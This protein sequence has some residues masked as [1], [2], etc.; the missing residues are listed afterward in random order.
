M[1]GRAWDIL[2]AVLRQVEACPEVD[3]ASAAGDARRF[4]PLVSAL[5]IVCRAANPARA[6]D[7]LSAMPDM[8]P[9]IERDGRRLAVYAF[10]ERVEIRVAAP[11]EYGT[12]LFLATGSTA[13][14]AAVQR[15]RP[16]AAL[17]SREEDVY[18]RAGLPFI[19]PEMRNAEGEL[20]AAA[21][22]ALPALVTRSDIRGDLHMH[23]NYSDG[24][25]TLAAMVAAA[26][27]LGYEYI[28]ITDHSEQAAALRTV[29]REQL[30]R[31]ADDIARIREQYPRMAVLHGIE[32]EIL[33]DGSLDF[34][35]AVLERLDVVL[36][37]LHDAAGHDAARLTERCI[38]AIR[39]PL[40]TAITHPANQLVGRRPGYDLRFEEIYAAAAETGTA[41]EIDGAPGHLDLDGP[42]ARA[43]VAAGVTVTIDSDCHRVLALDA[44]MRLGIGTARRG[45]VEPRN[46]LNTRPLAEVQAFVAAKRGSGR[47]PQP[48]C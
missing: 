47:A 25:D 40:V 10:G 34:E 23:T 38:Q 44:Q 26:D 13:H 29:T 9:P 46:V 45:W 24:R 27:A 42:H 39:H 33:P 48:A 8:G 1:L 12:V 15:R 32:V 30:A 19:P 6:I 31:Q 28:A 11:D 16:G 43:A 3:A 2:N 17:A 41:L 37:S 35:D 7:A 18:A 20:E 14:V 22:G 4:E 21:R 36:A 5:A